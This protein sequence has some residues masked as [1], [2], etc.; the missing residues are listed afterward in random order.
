MASASKKT[1]GIKYTLELNEE[2][3]KALC[4]LLTVAN[5]YEGEG[6]HL[7]DIYYALCDEGVDV[8]GYTNDHEGDDVCIYAEDDAPADD[9]DDEDEG[10]DE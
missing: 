7:E 8:E 2:E 5:F 9:S 3:A 10:D 6:V 4:E 1:A